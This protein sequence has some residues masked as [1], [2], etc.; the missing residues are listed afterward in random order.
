MPA[1]KTP[2]KRGYEYYDLEEYLRWLLRRD[3]PKDPTKPV[4]MKFCFDGATLTSGK[5]KQQ[6]VAAFNLLYSDFTDAQVCNF[7]L[8]I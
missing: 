1:I 7:F 5:R 6:E 2:G 4:V 8:L 3:P